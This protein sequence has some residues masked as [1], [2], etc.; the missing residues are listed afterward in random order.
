M[1]GPLGDRR[2]R[3]RREEDDNLPSV[4]VHGL[5]SPGRQHSGKTR[6]SD[7]RH[8]SPNSALLGDGGGQAAEK[9]TIEHG[10]RRSRKYWQRGSSTCG[11][12]KPPCKKVRISPL[13]F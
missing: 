6:I 12:M 2:Y 3:R 8:T 10:Y 4:R 11:V 13:K 1:P 9:D 7:D 5:K